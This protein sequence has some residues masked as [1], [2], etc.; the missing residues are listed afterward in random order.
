MTLKNKWRNLVKHENYKERQK[1]VEPYTVWEEC[2]TNQVSCN[3]L[4]WKRSLRSSQ[5]ISVILYK[6]LLST[7]ILITDSSSALN[8]LAIFPKQRPGLIK[9]PLFTSAP[10]EY[11]PSKKQKA[12]YQILIPH[13]METYLSQKKVLEL[14]H[15]PALNSEIKYTSSGWIID[16]LEEAITIFFIYSRNKS[17][18]CFTQICIHRLPH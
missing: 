14:A 3:H 12:D 10:S 2:R 17:N 6:S 18:Q 5:T 7:L 16:L 9:R 4:V 1:I 13:N 8:P 11:S 15:L